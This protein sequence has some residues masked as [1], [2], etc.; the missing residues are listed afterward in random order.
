MLASIAASSNGHWKQEASRTWPRAILP[1]APRRSQARK[2][3]RNASTRA[4]PSLRSPGGQRAAIGLAGSDAS[5]ALMSAMLASTSRMRT[6]TRAFTSPW[7]KTG[8]SNVIWS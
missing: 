1:S 6:Q 3:P 2:S 4:T 8:T 5:H 7:E